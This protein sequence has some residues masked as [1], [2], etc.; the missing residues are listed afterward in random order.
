MVLIED[1][2]QM[3]WL[4]GVATALGVGL[5]VTVEV[6]PSVRLQLSLDTLTKVRVTSV[7][8]LLAVMV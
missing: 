4:E 2:E 7:R 1:V 3:V 8:A 6:V 5:T